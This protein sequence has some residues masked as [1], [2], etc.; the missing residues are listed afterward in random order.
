ME[1]VREHCEIWDRKQLGEERGMSERIQKY[2]KV[3][4]TERERY[5]KY[6]NRIRFLRKF[7]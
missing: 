6:T 4:H 7:G 2:K 3:K 5:K 1:I